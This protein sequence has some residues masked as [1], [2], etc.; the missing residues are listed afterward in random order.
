MSRKTSLALATAA[1]LL[2]FGVWVSHPPPIRANGEKD[3]DKG[4]HAHV[5]APLEYADVHVPL[6]VW[7]DSAMIARGKEIY[8]AKC[9]VC[10]GDTGDGKGPA[11]A[12][13]PLKPSDFRDKAG[14][15]EMRDNYWFWRVSEGGQVEP[16]KGKGSAMPPWKGELSVEERWAVM[17]YQHTFSGHDGP[18]VPWE[19]PESVLVGRDIYVMACFQCH[20]TEGRGD[21]TVGATLS[22]RRA[23]QP[24]DFT[25]A[26]FKLRSTPSG[27][28]PITADL[29]RT[30]TEGVRGPLGAMTIG[31]RGHRIMPSFR[32]MPEEQRLEVIE[33]V[34]SLNRGFWERRDIKTVT[35]PAPPPV[36]PERLARGKQLYADAEC[37]AC[38]GAGGR[39]DGPSAPTLK[40][41]REL[42]IAATDLTRPERFKNGGRPEDIY[43]TLVTGLAGTPMPSY[44]DSLEPEQAWDLVYY[45]LTLSNE[46]RRAV[47]AR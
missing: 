9:A 10:H 43:R 27:Q 34:K 33:Y 37:L 18:H 22:P 1:A 3:E 6:S 25:S 40:D 36:T 31:L 35:V 29:F 44:A 4:G 28:L 7:T 42:P 23:P 20:G 46:R 16:F 8:T 5:P 26:E 14:V 15:A 38:H 19:H 21:G 13:L 2:V 24:R 12:A 17:A 45:V 30:V 47:E 32:H 39:G 11:G 41:N